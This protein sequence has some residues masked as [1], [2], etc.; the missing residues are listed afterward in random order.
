MRVEYQRKDQYFEPK[1]EQEKQLLEKL[2]IFRDT[3][4]SN[5]LVLPSNPQT[6]L[7]LRLIV[8]CVGLRL[9]TGVNTNG[10]M[11]F[12]VTKSGSSSGHASQ[13]ASTSSSRPI[14][15]QGRSRSN[16]SVVDVPSD[17][18]PM[19]SSFNRS[20]KSSLSTSLSATAGTTPPLSRSIPT[21]A[22]VGSMSGN[23]QRC[24]LQAKGPDGSKGFSAGRGKSISNP[25]SSANFSMPV[26]VSG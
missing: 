17:S 10:D 2:V 18:S 20:R 4:M 12:V 14:L 8:Q 3:S 15:I 23:S 9:T 19:S 13:R 5:E 25:I 11:Q 21:M 1:N 16:S 7:A 22:G 24:N 6:N 26:S